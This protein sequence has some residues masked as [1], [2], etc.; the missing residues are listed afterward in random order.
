[1]TEIID[2]F[3][4]LEGGP[5]LEVIATNITA[6]A[7]RLG[8]LTKVDLTK[9]ITSVKI[10]DTMRGSS[11]LTIVFNDPEFELMDSNFFDCDTNGRLDPIDLEYGE[12]SAGDPQWWRITQA[13]PKAR[14]VI[15]TVWME[16]AAV[17]L[18][19]HKGPLKASR[20]KSTRAEFID[21][22]CRKV[23]AGGGIHLQS[24][25]LHKT[26]QISKPS[27]KE[28]KKQQKERDRTVTKSPGISTDEVL[29]VQGVKANPRQIALAERILDVATKLD[30]PELAVEAL[31]CAAI[32]ETGIKENTGG[33]TG[34][35]FIGVFQGQRQYFKPTDTERQAHYFLVG[36]K[37]FGGGGAIHQANTQP[38][39]HP[40][41]IAADTE[42]S[43]P[44]S[45]LPN[46]AAAQHYYGQYLDEAKALIAAYGGGS[47]SST[48]YTKQYNF[49]V[50]TASDPHED[51]WT[52]ANRLA[53]EVKW[54]FFMDCINAS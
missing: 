48:T 51:Y 12:T 1:L 17:Y 54:A 11:T 21:K 43:Y 53:N 45:A 3:D 22:L 19:A 29:K 47:F 40:G 10:G 23:K 27:E 18:M 25:D 46:A 42:V 36:G 38:S 2:P 41:L 24:H 14:A 52:A 32:G 9:A 5:D 49:T 44:N 34:N 37:G 6:E 7:K 26:Q 15:E 50:G 8:K 33:G 30:A 31:M 39:K 4:V 20:A 28:T 13:N 35:A 16:R